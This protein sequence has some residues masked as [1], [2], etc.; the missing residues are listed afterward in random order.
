MDYLD[1]A[2]LLLRLTVGLT[3]AAHGW[4]KFR[5]GGRIEGTAGWF[6]SIGMR[7]GRLHA[8]LAACTEIGAGLLLAAGAVTPLAAAAV[9]GLMVVAAWTVHLRNG[10]F[11]V[12]NGY[13][14]NL[15]LAMAAVVIALA[16]PGQLSVDRSLPWYPHIHGWF[17]LL[18]AMVVG[19]GAGAGQLLI[20]YR[21][22]AQA[23][24]T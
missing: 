22:P 24:A 2:L 13:E 6:D 8:Y 17:G 3:M 14:Y 16:G 21:P 19:I 5:R 4:S 20:F 7:P 10:F 18:V 11:S 9:I 12:N 1:V 23:T 15:I